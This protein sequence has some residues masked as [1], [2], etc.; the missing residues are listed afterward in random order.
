MPK[1]T[2]EDL[3]RPEEK[4]PDIEKLFEQTNR[5]TIDEAFKKQ[6]LNELAKN[7]DLLQFFN[8]LEIPDQERTIYLITQG[9]EEV[10]RIARILSEILNKKYQPLKR[11]CQL[12]LAWFDVKKV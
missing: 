11:S 6:I 1:R 10:R 2:F 5:T 7:Q 4:N 8:S 12:A 3:F 9:N